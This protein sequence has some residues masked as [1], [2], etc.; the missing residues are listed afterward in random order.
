MAAVI[1]SLDPDKDRAAVARLFDAAADYIRI[2]RGAAPGPAVTDEFFTDTPRAVIRPRHTG[3]GL[4]P[5]S[6][7]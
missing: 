6:S 4:P 5:R 2:E 1:R 7:P 3:S